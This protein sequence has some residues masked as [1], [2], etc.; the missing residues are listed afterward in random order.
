MS[1][2]KCSESE[3]DRVVIPIAKPWG[4]LEIMH[5][6]NLTEECGMFTTNTELN[7]GYGCLAKQ[8]TEHPGCCYSFACPIATEA[9]EEDSQWNSC[10]SPGEW[11]IVHSEFK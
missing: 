6:D 8:N 1:E 2:T 10:F 3:L 7:S 4:Q 5:I 9:D 11:M